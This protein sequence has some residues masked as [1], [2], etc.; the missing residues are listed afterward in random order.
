[1]EH[2]RQRSGRNR[3]GTK[4]ILA[5]L[6]IPKRLALDTTVLVNYL[7]SGRSSALVRLEETAQLATTIINIFELYVGAYKSKDTRTNLTAVKGLRSTLQVL[8]LSE[9]AAEKAGKIMAGLESH[10]KP[11]EIRDLLIGSICLEQGYAI[12]TDNVTHFERI[13]ELQVIGERQLGAG[14]KQSTARDHD[15]Y[16]Y[17][18]WARSS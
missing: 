6:E 2:E 7:R 8:T 9:A 15:K 10:G 13:P 1:M 16:L 5:S 17:G 4:R 18:D 3:S 14:K 12:L 11:I